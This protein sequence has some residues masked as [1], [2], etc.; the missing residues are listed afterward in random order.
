M[1]K[2]DLAVHLLHSIKPDSAKKRQKIKH[3]MTVC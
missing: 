1:T 3:I 2:K